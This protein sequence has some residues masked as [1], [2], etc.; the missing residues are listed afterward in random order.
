MH[1]TFR[2]MKPE[3]KVTLVNVCIS[4]CSIGVYKSQETMFCVVAPDV[5][6]SSIWNLLHVTILAPRILE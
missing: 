5:C 3:G 6:G 2:V 4:C 1:I